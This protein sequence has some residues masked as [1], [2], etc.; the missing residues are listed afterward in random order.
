M[1]KELWNTVIISKNVDVNLVK[2]LVE[3]SYELTKNNI[4]KR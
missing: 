1:N 4:H 3:H 2:E